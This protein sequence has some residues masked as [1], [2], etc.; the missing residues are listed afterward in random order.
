MLVIREL[1]RALRDVVAYAVASRRVGL[2]VV[3]ALVVLAVV[4]SATVTTVG[5]VAIYPLL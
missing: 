5:P 4:L 3:I 1:A 2:L